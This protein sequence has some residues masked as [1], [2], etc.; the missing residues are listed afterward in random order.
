MSKDSK[1]NDKSQEPAV[2]DWM[3]KAI[4]GLRGGKDLRQDSSVPAS[5]EE[6]FPVGASIAKEKELAVEVQESVN[7]AK[8]GDYKSQI[9]KLLQQVERA[10]KV[11]E[12]LQ[13]SNLHLKGQV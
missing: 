5:T 9:Q 3:H 13:E 1:N 7:N 2:P 6:I 12:Q 4:G 10:D 8:I 11:Q